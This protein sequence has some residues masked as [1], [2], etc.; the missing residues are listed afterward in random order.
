MDDRTTLIVGLGGTTRPGSSTEQALHLAL[1][2]AREAGAETEMFSGP[3]LLL[4][5]YQAEPKAGDNAGARLIASLRRADGVIVASPVYHGG[6]SGLLKN[7][8]D[9]TEEMR[10]DARVYLD[11]RAVGAIASGFGSQGPAVVL[12]QLRDITHALRG[13]PVPL[14]VAINSAIVRFQDGTCSDDAIAGQI[15]TMAR[16]VVFFAASCKGV[17]LPQA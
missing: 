12:G 6:I 8:I 7:A 2:C 1:A 3:D 15:K 17:E 16:Q 14:G 9:Y 11:R 5:M 10:N 13:W 4:P